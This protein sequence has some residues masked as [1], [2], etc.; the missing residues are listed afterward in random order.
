MIATLRPWKSSKPRK[1]SLV[2]P[3]PRRPRIRYLPICAGIGLAADAATGGT[4]T[5][6]VDD[7]DIEGV[8]A[9]G[10][11]AP[12]CD[13]KYAATLALFTVSADFAAARHEAAKP[14]S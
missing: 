4:E 2:A 6:A 5:V 13:Q 11:L 7:D 9:S 10:I 12:T 14:A 1:T 8:L 3:S